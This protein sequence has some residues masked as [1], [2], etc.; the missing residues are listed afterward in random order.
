MI[1]FELLKILCCPETHQPLA[2]ADAATLEGLNQRIAAGTLRNRSGA[3]VS[4]PLPAALIR[5]DRQLVYPV[6]GR[7]PV[8]LVDEGIFVSG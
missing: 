2:E 6:R 7:L 3:P 5:E 8:L 1:P 4:E